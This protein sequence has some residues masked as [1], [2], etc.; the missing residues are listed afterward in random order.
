MNNAVTTLQRYIVMTST[1]KMPTNCWGDYRHV[2]VVELEP[3]FTKRPSMISERARGVARIVIHYGPQ[4][5][6]TTARCAY[7]KTLKRAQEYT[8]ELNALSV[9]ELQRAMSSSER[10]QEAALPSVELKER[11]ELIELKA[12]MTNG[13][14]E[15]NS[16]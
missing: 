6:G 7:Q 4:N 5:V 2:A 10:D 15:A 3:G 1:A 16:R 9:P 14:V 11:A 13:T 12:S 8:D